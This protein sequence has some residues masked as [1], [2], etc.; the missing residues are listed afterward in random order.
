[1]HVLRKYIPP[2]MTAAVKEGIRRATEYIK[3]RDSKGKDEKVNKEDVFKAETEKSRAFGTDRE[4][5]DNWREEIDVERGKAANQEVGKGRSRALGDLDKVEN[6]PTSVPGKVTGVE[7]KLKELEEKGGLEN[8]AEKR[9]AEAAKTFEERIG[10]KKIEE[11]LEEGKPQEGKSWAEKV[12]PKEE[13]EFQSLD[14]E[15][16]RAQTV[17][18]LK[19][20]SGKY[21][22]P[23]GKNGSEIMLDQE[24][25]KQAIELMGENRENT[26]GELLKDR[27]VS[28]PAND[29]KTDAHKATIKS[30]EEM[31]EVEEGTF[32]D[33]VYRDE[34]ATEQL[35][36]AAEMD[37]SPDM[38]MDAGDFD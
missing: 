21:F 35:E 17:D 32:H 6:A 3:R 13:M 23:E 34:M 24:E 4:L 14:Q 10:G 11:I 37:G 28:E 38:D 8:E 29:N 9:S 18:L 20:D 33:E 22:M 30:Y 36:R 31:Q 5:K 1:M 16:E 12:R 25:K 26:P 2:A 15:A 7:E 27:E 19:E